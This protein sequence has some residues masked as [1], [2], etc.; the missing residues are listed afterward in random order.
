MSSPIR[1]AA[2]L[3]ILALPVLVVPL[4]GQVSEKHFERPPYYTGKVPADVTS[5]GH[6]PVRYQ[7]GGSHDAFFDPTDDAGGPVAG[8][9]AEMNAYL[10]EL[11]MTVALDAAA[12]GD[13]RPPDVEF[14]CDPSPIEECE[15][16]DES[17]ALGRQGTVLRLAAIDPS[18]NWREGAAE[19]IAAGGVD[20][21][22]VI[23][24]EVGQ[25]FV[26]QRGLRGDKR[27][28]M[29]T[30]Y[31]VEL[32]WLTS[33]ETPV[34]VLQLTGAVVDAEGKVKRIGAEGIS[35]RRTR[36][37]LSAIEAQELITE[38]DVEAV[39]S[40]RRED[41]PGAPIAWQVALRNLASGLIGPVRAS[42]TEGRAGDQRPRLR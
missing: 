5:V 10:A 35:A 23:T 31:E 24:L 38:E 42:Q 14:G 15:E 8:L 4:H 27:V 40:L 33:L 21:A 3:L 41:L 20:A 36:F 29:G 1:G 6:F 18:R 34:T 11:G 30:D 16:R 17:R 25:Y 28:R 39:R 26:R 9:V 19:E 22:V 32:P 37:S 2:A 12:L 7:R 13:H